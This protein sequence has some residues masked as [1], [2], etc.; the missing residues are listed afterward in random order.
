MEVINNKI[1]RRYS[2]ISLKK[3]IKQK[4]DSPSKPRK[5][6]YEKVIIII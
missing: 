4:F 2:K 6:K 3:P 1:P 5:I